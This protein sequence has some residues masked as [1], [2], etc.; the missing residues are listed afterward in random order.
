M[1]ACEPY[2]RFCKSQKYQCTNTSCVYIYVY[3][4]TGFAAHQQVLNQSLDVLGSL[5]G[6]RIVRRQLDKCRQEILT[7]LH[8]FLHFLSSDKKKWMYYLLSKI[9]NWQIAWWQIDQRC[10][11]SIQYQS[12]C[13]CDQCKLKWMVSICAEYPKLTHWHNRMNSFGLIKELTASVTNQYI[14]HT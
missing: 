12:L 5:R 1:S 2:G 14:V 7:L 3:W 10:S 13:A 6:R 8:I 9:L 11:N 4:L